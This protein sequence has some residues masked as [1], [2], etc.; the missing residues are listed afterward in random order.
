MNN[1]ESGSKVPLKGTPEYRRRYWRLVAIRT[2]AWVVLAAGLLFGMLAADETISTVGWVVVG[3]SLIVAIVMEFELHALVTKGKGGG[4][5]QK[6][7]GT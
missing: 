7:E 6:D 1:P 3:M 4:A 2:A 5:K